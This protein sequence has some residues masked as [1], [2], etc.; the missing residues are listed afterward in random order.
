[1][2]KILVALLISALVAPTGVFAQTQL[3]NERGEGTIVYR[4]FSFRRES[5]ARL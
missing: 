4:H 1:M 5:C 2:R 3:T